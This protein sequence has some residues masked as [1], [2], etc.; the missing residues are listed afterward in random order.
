MTSSEIA[1]KTG[2]QLSNVSSYINKLRGAG[3]VTTDTKPRI[4]FERIIINSESI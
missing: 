4:K 2:I 3:L 1:K